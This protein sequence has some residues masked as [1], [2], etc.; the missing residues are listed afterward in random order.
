MLVGI[1]FTPVEFVQTT[2]D[3]SGQPRNIAPLPRSI[4]RERG[5][6]WSDVSADGSKALFT[7]SN[8]AVPPV[9]RPALLSLPVNGS[10]AEPVT[11]L[12]NPEPVFGAR[13]SPDGRWV[14]YGVGTRSSSLF[15]RTSSGVG[16]P[17]QIAADGRSPVWR[18]D[19]KEIVCISGENVLSIS[20]QQ[21]GSELRFDDPHILFSGIRLA[22]G[23]V[24][25]NMPL[26]VSHD[27][28]RIFWLQGP[29]QP[30]ANIIH[31][32][33]GAIQ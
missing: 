14:V 26:A 22:P 27:G 4:S 19:S 8:S 17:R 3:S 18:G 10:A 6:F 15:V 7:L 24:L 16:S 9:S 21:A 12:E 29:N 31:I 33:I 2:A 25:A 1:R 5:F 20:V 30:D 11:L 13:F 23:L 32:K 28:S